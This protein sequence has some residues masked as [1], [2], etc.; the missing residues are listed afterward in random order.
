MAYS[1]CLGAA[2]GEPG[3]SSYPSAFYAEH[4]RIPIIPGEVLHKLVDIVTK[5]VR[6]KLFLFAATVKGREGAPR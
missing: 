2:V 5:A 3:V 1:L 4:V 6:N